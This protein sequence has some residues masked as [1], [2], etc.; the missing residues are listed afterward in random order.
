MNQTTA[1]QDYYSAQQF[2]IFGRRVMM[3]VDDAYKP[4]IEARATAEMS[5]DGQGLRELEAA[6]QNASAAIRTM[7][8]GVQVMMKPYLQEH[9]QYLARKRNPAAH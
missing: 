3:M 4:V 5:A 9:E 6:L 1:V 8:S 7:Q 2:H